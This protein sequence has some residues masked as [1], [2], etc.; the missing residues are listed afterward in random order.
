MSRE[1][2]QRRRGLSSKVPTRPPGIRVSSDA[3]MRV[4]APRTLLLL[5]SGALALTETWAG[6]CGVGRETASAGRSE[7]TAG[8]GAGPGEPRGE[9]GRAGLSL[10]SPPGSH[11]LRY[12]GT[13]VSRPGRGEPHFIYVGYV[14]DTQFVRFDS[15]AASP[16]TEPRAPWVEQEGPE[17]W[18]EQTRRAKARAQA[19]RADLRTL[20][21]YYNQSEAGSHTI[22]WMAGCDLGPNGRLLRGYHQSAYDGRDYIALNRDLRSW[23]AA[24]MAAQNTQRK[25]EATRYA[26]R[27]RAYLEGTCLEW[28]HRYLENGKETLQRAGTR[29]SGEPSPSPLDRPGWPPMRGGKWD[30]R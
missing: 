14:D 11:S 3:E 1:A 20:R 23:I 19:D 5:L 9:E 13:A 21:G 24:D 29:G 15:D 27:F 26:E 6:E 28:L 12:F 18:E 8:G 7:G 4:M 25:W 17:Y 16:R 22:Q 2:N 30:Q 10:S